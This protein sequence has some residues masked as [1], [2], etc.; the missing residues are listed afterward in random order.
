[1]ALHRWEEFRIICDS[2]QWWICVFLCRQAL[3]SSLQDRGPTSQVSFATETLMLMHK[4]VSVLWPDLASQHTFGSYM[5]TCI[6]LCHYIY[7]S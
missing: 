7:R 6:T 2:L 3:L 4:N 5:E 1:M